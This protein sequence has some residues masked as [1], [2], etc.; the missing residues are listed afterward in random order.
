MQ[1]LGFAE[2]FSLSFKLISLV[3]EQVILKHSVLFGKSLV[4][5]TGNEF[6]HF[7]MKITKAARVVGVI[8]TAQGKL[9]SLDGLILSEIGQ[10]VALLLSCIGKHGSAGDKSLFLEFL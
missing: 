1:L 7:P 6:E 8:Q 10:N 2:L 4:L 3:T 5:V 9:V